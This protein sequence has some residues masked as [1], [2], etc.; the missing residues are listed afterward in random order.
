MLTEAVILVVHNGARNQDVLGRP[1]V[2]SIRVVA[3]LSLVTSRVVVGHIND[4]EVG[5]R[6]DAHKLNWPA[7]C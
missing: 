1:N 2:K 3:K 4:I 5:S 6:V 7:P